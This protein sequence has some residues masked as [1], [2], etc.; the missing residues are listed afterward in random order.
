MIN[1]YH[2]FIPQGAQILKP[3][4]DSMSSTTSH[5]QWTSQASEAFQLIKDT[6]TDISLLFHPMSAETRYSTFDR[7]L[8]AIL[9]SQMP[10]DTHILIYNGYSPYQRL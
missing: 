3:L 1:F 4:N 8:L 2:R 7:E 5:I 6:L 10:T 9:F